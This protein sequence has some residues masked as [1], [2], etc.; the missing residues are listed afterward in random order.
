MDGGSG[1]LVG[2]GPPPHT[3]ETLW[4]I[5][6]PRAERL[7]LAVGEISFFLII[8]IHG[9]KDVCNLQGLK[10]PCE[11]LRGN[12]SCIHII[13]IQ[14]STKPD[15]SYAKHHLSP[16]AYKDSFYFIF[17]LSSSYLL[18]TEIRHDQWQE[19][20]QLSKHIGKW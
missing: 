8:R 5:C 14:S 2:L 7:H 6:H 3:V 15:S 10:G 16:S 12:F 13:F 4:R 17:V 20:G 19:V 18:I 9:L 1:R 11:M